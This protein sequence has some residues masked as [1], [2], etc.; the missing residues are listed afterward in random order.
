MAELG[1]A[2]SLRWAA[3]PGH[4]WHCYVVSIGAAEGQVQHGGNSER[5]G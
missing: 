5:P 1:T 3:H 4:E 2:Q